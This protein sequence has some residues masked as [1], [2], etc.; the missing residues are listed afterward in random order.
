MVA[1]WHADLNKVMYLREFG[2]P[3]GMS[4]AVLNFNRLP[5]LMTAVCRRVIR[6]LSAAFCGDNVVVDCA[7]S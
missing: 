2:H 5:T 7:F 6:V 4:A 1:L 3:Y